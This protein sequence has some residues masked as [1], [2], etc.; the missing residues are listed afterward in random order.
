MLNSYDR[1]KEK[2]ER[3]VYALATGEGDVRSRLEKAYNYLRI[4]RSED[5][6]SIFRQEF[7]VILKQLTRFG[8]EYFPDGTVYRNA[9]Q[10][11]MSRIKN[12]TGKKI[13]E[14]IYI[15][16]QSLRRGNIT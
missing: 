7:S 16:N 11:T 5:I 9:I 15:I 13:A 8:P 2:F 10:H 12:A 14:H 4:L 3:A 1:C 6:P